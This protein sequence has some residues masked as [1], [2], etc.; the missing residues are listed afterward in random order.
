[1]SL[2]LYYELFKKTLSFSI[3]TGIIGVKQFIYIGLKDMIGDN[4]LS[5]YRWM[6]DNS[7]MVYSDF[8]G[9]IEPAKTYQQCIVLNEKS[10]FRWH[11]FECSHKLTAVCETGVVSTFQ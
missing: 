6:V 11:D 8:N 9:S 1:M 4:Q 7:P 5:S 3:I 10:S 2:I